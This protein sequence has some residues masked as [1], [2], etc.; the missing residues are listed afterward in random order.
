MPENDESVD[1]RYHALKH[2]AITILVPISLVLGIYLFRPVLIFVLVFMALVLSPSTDSRLEDGHEV[3]TLEGFRAPLADEVVHKEIKIHHT[4]KYW[5][6]SDY[7]AKGKLDVSKG[8]SGIV[9]LDSKTDD[10]DT[11]PL[12]PVAITLSD[13]RHKGLTVAIPRDHL[14]YK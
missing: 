6:D 10:D 3:I 13:G 1:I 2:L 7:S 11:N 14:R 12:R 9:K 5:F 4:P 8:T